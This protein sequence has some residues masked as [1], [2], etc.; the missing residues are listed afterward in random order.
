MTESAVLWYA[1]QADTNGTNS[2]IR[3][4]LKTILTGG[5]QVFVSGQFGSGRSWQ[6]RRRSAEGALMEP[7]TKGLLPNRP[8][9]IQL[10]LDGATFN[11]NVHRNLSNAYG[12]LKILPGLTLDR[13][14]VP[15]DGVC[16]GTG[17]T[18]YQGRDYTYL[19]GAGVFQ[20]AVSGV[21][22]FKAERKLAGR[23]AIGFLTSFQNAGTA[24]LV[25]P[26]RS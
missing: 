11:T 8:P 26:H 10:N 1:N 20:H 7:L 13:N 3:M 9:L 4:P 6:L 23:K 12:V 25:S 24:Y 22:S 17:S 14:G 16:L 5:C 15:H 2:P 19:G 21:G 18:F